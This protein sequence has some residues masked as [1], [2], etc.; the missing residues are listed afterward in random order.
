M[1]SI[2]ADKIFEDK[3]E[4]IRI[5]DQIWGISRE[6]IGMEVKIEAL[7]QRNKEIELE[8]LRRKLLEQEEKQRELENET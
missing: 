1:E 6:I 2:T 4:W 8:V 3:N 7:L 5:R